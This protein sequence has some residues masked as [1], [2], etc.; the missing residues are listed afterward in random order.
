MAATKV[1]KVRML[2]SIAGH[3]EP[4]YNLAEFS[5]DQVKR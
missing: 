2:I 5:S 1:V 3:S 4:M